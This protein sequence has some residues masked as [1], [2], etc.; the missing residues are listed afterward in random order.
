MKTIFALSL[1]ALFASAT[2]V[3]AAKGPKYDRRLTS[4]EVAKL[5]PLYI[6]SVEQHAANLPSSSDNQVLWN[7]AYSVTDPTYYAFKDGKVIGRQSHTIET[8]VQGLESAVAELKAVTPEQ[9]REEAAGLL[10]GFKGASDAGKITCRLGYDSEFKNDTGR[11]VKCE[12]DRSSAGGGGEEDE[13]YLDIRRIILSI[14][15]A[16]LEPVSPLKLEHLTAG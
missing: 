1:L 15:G 9:R 12:D 10:A 14:D 4:R 2:E 11:I 6:A 5:L 3:S 13:G 16:S 7:A 8:L